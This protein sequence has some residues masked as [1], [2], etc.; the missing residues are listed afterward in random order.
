METPEIFPV[1]DPELKM[2]ASKPA[3]FR[4]NAPEPGPVIVSGWV[5][6]GRSAVRVKPE[7]VSVIASAA[8]PRRRSAY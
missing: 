2:K 8:V 7:P 6:A 5:M 4:V 3:A 1:V